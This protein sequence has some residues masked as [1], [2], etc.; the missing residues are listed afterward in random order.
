VAGSSLTVKLSTQDAV[1]SGAG[2]YRIEAGRSGVLAV[3]GTYQPP[4]ALLTFKY[5]SGDTALFAATAADS[6]HMNGKLTYQD[7]T[8]VELGLVRQ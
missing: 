7:G 5:D 4:V 6:S 8:T 2:V 3:A 1:V